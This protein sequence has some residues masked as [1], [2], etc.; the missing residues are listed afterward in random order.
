[1]PKK[2]K[3]LIVFLLLFTFNSFFQTVSAKYVIEATTVVAKISIA[4][5]KPDIELMDI[6]SSNVAYPTYANH[7][8]KI[9]GHLKIKKKNLE[10]NNLSADTLKIAVGNANDIIPVTFH[11]FSFQYE[12]ATEKI[13]EFSFSNVTSNG[14]LLLLVPE[15][16]LKTK[17][18][19]TNDKKTFS[20]NLMIDNIPPNFVFLETTSQNR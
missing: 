18:G 4:R 7:T 19:L 13:Y 11:S 10:Q 5:Y 3:I 17:A 2:F 6:V 14:T 12:T 16:V 1:M 9:T 15:G 8:H 20:T